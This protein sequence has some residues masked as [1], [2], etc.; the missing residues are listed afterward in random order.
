M[1]Q[2]REQF[3]SC[4]SGWPR[5]HSIGQAG[6][7]LIEITYS[8]STGVK[9]VCHHNTIMLSLGVLYILTGVTCYI[10]RNVSLC[11]H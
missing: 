2:G 8:A 4:S 9:E 3:L 1:G 10:I 6:L 7:E 11:G 5:S